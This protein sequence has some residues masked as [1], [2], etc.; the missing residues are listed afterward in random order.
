MYS[1]N[2]IL[3]NKESVCAYFTNE[4]FKSYIKATYYIV[5]SHLENYVKN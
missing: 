4:W 5:I 1:I 2:R 3:A